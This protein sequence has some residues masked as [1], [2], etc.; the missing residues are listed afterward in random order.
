MRKL[1]VFNHVSLDGYFTDAKGDMSFAHKDPK[2]TEWN[3]FV[4]GNASGN[5]MLLFGRVTYD[6]MAG[7][8]PTPMAA[9][10]MP[11]VAAGMNAMPKAVFSR[12]MTKAAWQNTSLLKGD[13][14]EEV[15]RLK[16]AAGPDMVI[17]GSGSIVAQLTGHGLIDEYQVVVNPVILGGGRTMFEGLASRAPLRLTSTRSFQN[18]SILACYE[19]VR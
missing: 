8:W 6:M 19:P 14:A 4:A 1:V 16:A 17:L 11:E 10:M 3:A 18:G 5:G 7:F 2:D 12:T 13:L 9:Q 15:R